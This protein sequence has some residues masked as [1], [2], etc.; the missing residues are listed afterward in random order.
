[1]SGVVVQESIEQPAEI[2][3][4][5]QEEFESEEEIQNNETI[6][7]DPAV[8]F[9]KS[10]ASSQNGNHASLEYVEPVVRPRVCSRICTRDACLIF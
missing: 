5:L 7:E 2:Q 6:P 3:E 1:M 9:N 4:F 10:E 8:F